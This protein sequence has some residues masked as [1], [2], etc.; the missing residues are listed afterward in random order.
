MQMMT[1]PDDNSNDQQS[2]RNCKYCS[3]RIEVTAKICRHCRCHQN[4]L[5]YCVNY[6]NLLP[7]LISICLLII[8]VFQLSEAKKERLA[9]SEARKDILEVSRAIIDIAEIIPRS[10]G[11]GGETSPED[12]RKLQEYSALLKEKLRAF[13]EKTARGN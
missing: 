11:Y 12:R 8:S 1:P 5:L 13:D 9:A 2:F 4:L 6:F 3:Q 7:A 10:T